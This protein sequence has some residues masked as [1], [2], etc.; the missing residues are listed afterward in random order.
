[1][2]RTPPSRV[3]ATRRAQATVDS[4][5]LRSGLPSDE[6]RVQPEQEVARRPVGTRAVDPVIAHELSEPKEGV[7]CIRVAHLVLLEQRGRMVVCTR[8]TLPQIDRS[9]L[10]ID[11]LDLGDG[12]GLLA[13]W[14]ESLVSF[15]EVGVLRREL[16]A[17]DHDAALRS[18]QAALEPEPRDARSLVEELVLGHAVESKVFPPVDLV[19]ASVPLEELREDPLRL[20]GPVAVDRE[21]RGQGLGHGANVR[22]SILEL[23]IRLGE[24]RGG[25]RDGLTPIAFRFQTKPLQPIAQ[26][27][28]RDAVVAIVRAD[29]LSDRGSQGGRVPP[30]DRVLDGAQVPGGLPKIDLAREPVERLKLLDGVAVD[31]RAEPLPNHAVEVN[32]DL[33]AKELVELIGP[34]PVPP[35]EPL[36]RGRLIGRVV[37]DVHGGIPPA[38]LDDQVDETFERPL[39]LGRR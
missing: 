18:L 33:S 25:S 3:R 17:V 1:M 27:E 39:L 30:R 20:L 10:E 14:F 23:L 32:E 26:P 8:D 5:G 9:M 29:R 4:P 16:V 37:V 38:T 13:A 22:Q 24:R 35:H 6:P 2:A 31:S 7:H 15:V 34:S 19:F 36:H 11:R 21:L 12:R 28:R